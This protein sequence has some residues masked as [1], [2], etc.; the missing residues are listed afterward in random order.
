MAT[1]A[2][3]TRTLRADARRNQEQILAAARDVFIERGPDAP[4]DEIARRAGVGIGT[5]Y[6][7]FPDRPALM[8]AVVLDALTR[9]AE[10]AETAAAEA[11]DSGSA[12]EALTTYLHAAL[13]L[14]V[15]A[16]IPALLDRLDLHDPELGPARERGAA[17]LERIVD[18]AK[19]EGS[20]A[21]EIAFGDLG[22]ILVRLSHPLPG[23]IGP[24]LDLELGHRQLDLVVAGLRAGRELSGPALSLDDLH[25]LQDQQ[26]KQDQ[27]EPG[28]ARRSAEHGGG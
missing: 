3:A 20:L 6:R 19:D 15:S 13:D 10:A 17:T 21:A 2:P 1:T 25:A 23:P 14:R 12:F 28:E 5:L 4:L 8:K 7:R 9:T 24:E 18:A 26:D 11:T 16:V 22:L 27:E